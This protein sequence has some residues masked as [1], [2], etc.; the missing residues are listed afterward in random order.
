M[1]TKAAAVLASDRELTAMERLLSLNRRAP[2]ARAAE[3]EVRQLPIAQL[4]PNPL[5][6]RRALDEE[7]LAEL[8]ESIRSRGVIQ[9]LLVRPVTG[10][11][12]AYEIVVGERRYSA[13]GRAGLDAVPC[14]VRRLDDREAFLLS[15]AENVAREDL[16][17]L[18]EAAAYRRILDE[19]YAANQGEVAAL[20]GV[21][22][23]RVN[24]KL[25][26]LNLDE[27]IQEHVRSQPP[28]GV[29]LTH[30]EELAR[31]Q[32][33]DA[34]HAL[35]LAVVERGMSTRDLRT[36]V[37]ALLRPAAAPPAV[38]KSIMAFDRGVRVAICPAKY[39]IRFPRAAN[40]TVDLPRIAGDV[41][42]LLVELKARASSQA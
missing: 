26:L 15:V 12:D 3:A 40:D 30:L 2:A 19:R 20:V 7:A 38:S 16:N 8:A 10:E 13:A 41:E 21:H 9:P 34:Q 33:G 31:L 4:R 14:I 5:Q 25:R 32:P 37:D 1:Q 23:T 42:R 18:D 35:Y 28:G 36:R 11:P 6:P 39:T 27:R 29:S 24:H 17:P 22:R